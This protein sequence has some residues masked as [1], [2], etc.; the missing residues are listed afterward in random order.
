MM[1]NTADANA[2]AANVRPLC[3]SRGIEPEGKVAEDAACRL[4]SLRM[5]ASGRNQHLL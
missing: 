3:I 1:T 2:N 5:M 4:G